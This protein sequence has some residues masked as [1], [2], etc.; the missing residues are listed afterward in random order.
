MVNYVI[1][2]DKF[3]K[4]VKKSTFSLNKSQVYLDYVIEKTTNENEQINCSEDRIIQ[5]FY[6]TFAP[7]IFRGALRGLRLYPLNLNRIIPAEGQRFAGRHISSDISIRCIFV[8]NPIS[9]N[10]LFC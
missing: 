7:D 8:K 9:N 3:L 5:I 4:K 6:T 10:P 1:N 2:C